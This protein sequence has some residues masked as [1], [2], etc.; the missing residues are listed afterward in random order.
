MSYMVDLQWV[1]LRSAADEK[2]TG[3]DKKVIEIEE[4]IHCILNR[5]WHPDVEIDHFSNS[6]LH[7]LVY[8]QIDS[9]CFPI[10]WHDVV[11][12]S[13]ATYKT[14][15][16][17]INCGKGLDKSLS[18]ITALSTMQVTV[19]F[20]LVPSQFVGE[21]SEGGQW[22]STSLPLFLQQHK[23]TCDTTAI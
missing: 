8:G 6:I 16:H 21:H 20:G 22:P 15:T 3:D 23:K 11:V 14:E 5:L 9:T 1:I 18:L 10:L 17:K 7:T 4:S 13:N 2:R 19:E 12:V